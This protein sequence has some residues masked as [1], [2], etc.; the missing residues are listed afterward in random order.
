MKKIIGYFFKKP[1]VL[2]DKKPFEII[3]PIDALY[4]GKEPVVESN[5]QILREIEKKYEYPI[6]SLHSFFI[7]S[8][9]AD[10]D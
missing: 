10:V 5:H 4:D 1:L 7:I 2:E 3:L 6:D 8:E 9:I